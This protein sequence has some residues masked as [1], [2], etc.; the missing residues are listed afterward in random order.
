MIKKLNEVTVSLISDCD[1]QDVIEVIL[2][3]GQSELSKDN[4]VFGLPRVHEALGSNQ[5]QV[6]LHVTFS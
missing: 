2:K 4:C 1:R 3:Q 6:S 5:K